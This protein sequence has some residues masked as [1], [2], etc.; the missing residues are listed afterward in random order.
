[1]WLEAGKSRCSRH[2]LFHHAIKAEARC[3][4]PDGKFLEGLQPFGH[5]FLN[6]NLDEHMIGGPFVVEE[7]AVL[8]RLERVRSQVE[9]FGNPKM[10]EILAPYCE[11]LPL[12]FEENH[13]PVFITSSEEV[14]VVAPVHELLAGRFLDLT[15]KEWNEI[16]TIEMHFKG[17]A[18]SGVALLHW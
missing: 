1:M 15:L 8:G 16:V 3:L 14:S 12:L 4:L 17:V 7:R 9:D 5:D 18:I 11:A 2:Q 10:G 13:F 6:W